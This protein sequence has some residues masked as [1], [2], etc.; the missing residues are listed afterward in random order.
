MSWCQTPRKGRGSLRTS[1]EDEC[2]A[3]DGDV[4]AGGDDPRWDAV[5]GRDLDLPARAEAARRERERDRLAVGVEEEKERVVDD[6][7]AIGRLVRD[8]LP[9]QEHAERVSVLALPVLLRH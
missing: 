1:Q 6:V 7:L 4:G 8:L 5:A 2:A 3:V 9:V